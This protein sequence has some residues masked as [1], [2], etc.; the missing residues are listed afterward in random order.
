MLLCQEMTG[1]QQQRKSE[2]HPEDIPTK[3]SL[4]IES[5]V[6][7]SLH[8]GGSVHMNMPCPNNAQ[9]K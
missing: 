9:I 2:D 3:C 7:A 8:G 4:I 1:S 5:G 6:S